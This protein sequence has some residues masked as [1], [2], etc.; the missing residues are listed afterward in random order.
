MWNYGGAGLDDEWQ[1]GVHAENR[2]GANVVGRAS[3]VKRKTTKPKETEPVHSE[4]KFES[5][6]FES[7]SSKQKRQL[8]TVMAT[9]LKELGVSSKVVLKAGGAYPTG[10]PTGGV[11]EVD[12]DVQDIK[13]RLAKVQFLPKKTVDPVGW[14][15]GESIGQYEFGSMAQ[16]KKGLMELEDCPALKVTT[17]AEVGGAGE[18]VTEIGLTVLGDQVGSWD[19]GRF[20]KEGYLLSTGFF[21]EPTKTPISA[22]GSSSNAQSWVFLTSTVV[23]RSSTSSIGIV[24]PQETGAYIQI[25]PGSP[26]SGN[27]TTIGMAL[28]QDLMVLLIQTTV[29]SKHTNVPNQ[30]L[31]VDP[32]TRLCL[33]IS[34][35]KKGQPLRFQTYQLTSVSR[36]TLDE[37]PVG[38]FLSRHPSMSNH[39]RIGVTCPT[40]PNTEGKGKKSTD[41]LLYEYTAGGL[42]YLGGS[43]LQDLVKDLAQTETDYAVS[44]LQTASLSHLGYKQVG[45]LEHSL[46]K[47][48]EL[49]PE[50]STSSL[51]A[52][53]FGA[54]TPDTPI[55]AVNLYGTNTY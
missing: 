40:N 14:L 27:A 19:R 35:V 22:P 52:D 38:V 24:H 28:H 41:L 33:V 8:E 45:S 30:E 44:L 11:G 21:G 18:G 49:S 12:L 16:A 53:I 47:I 10:T 1:P 37:Y 13:D 2:W 55:L 20:V 51:P 15:T 32:D 26:N 7:L 46:S 39:F 4:V 25:V 9:K 34:A 5:A 3:Q 36:T 48:G 42:V 17:W 6:I 43:P 29:K 23:F 54:M 50:N 31:T